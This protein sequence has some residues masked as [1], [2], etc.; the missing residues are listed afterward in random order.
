[1]SKNKRSHVDDLRGA[2]KLA[3]DA[4]K[5]ITSLVKAMHQTI[6]SSPETLG[7][8]LETP[9]RVATELVYNG[10]RAVTGLV[11]LGID[12]A[13]GQ[14]ATLL[15]ESTPGTERE[16]VLAVL[17]GVLGDY[18]E[19]TKNPLAIKMR[20][21]KHDAHGA[22]SKK[23]PNATIQAT[24][25]LIL[26]HGSCM[27]DELWS[28]NGHD[29]GTALARDLGYT[30]VY[31]HYNSG[32]HVSTNGAAL[33]LLIEDTVASSPTPIDEIAIIAHSMGGLVARSA[34]HNAEKQAL[35]WRTKLR[36]I[37]FLGTPHHGSP[38]ERAGNW[39]DTLLG[40]SRYSAPLARL[41]KIRS[42]GVT[43]LRYGNVLD[44]HWQGRD[45]FEM[46]VDV[47]TPL[48]LPKSV[49]C[50]AIAGSVTDGALGE[51]RG[52]GLV[53]VKSALGQHAV[54]EL[55]LAIPEANRFTA[56]GVWHSEL[57]SNADVYK[58][59]YSWLEPALS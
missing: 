40:I 31:L 2:S 5:G 3:I 1:M 54:A 32:L 23:K 27:N 4:T 6:G 30:P 55:S 11:G 43:D 18:L 26:V 41:G 29:H 7:K 28:H 35:G 38:L 46:A 10:I 20:F 13:L 49:T 53:P 50:F 56:K 47:R 12:G 42:A 19:E 17:N 52:D 8:P 22:R 15:G 34:C 44:E 33:A 36:S 24:K 57:L 51:L 25:L 16:V 59:M 14:L 39:V 58:T 45:R 9:T 37:V 21:Y 48:P